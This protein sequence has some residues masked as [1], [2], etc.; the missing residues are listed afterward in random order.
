MLVLHA[1]VQLG[2]DVEIVLVLVLST[3]AGSHELSLVQV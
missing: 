1:G 2:I 3:T